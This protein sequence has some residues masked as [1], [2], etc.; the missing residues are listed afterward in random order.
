MQVP[1]NAP[2]PSPSPAGLVETIGGFIT[3]AG[4]YA[5]MAISLLGWLTGHWADLTSIGALL[6]ALYQAFRAAQ[7]RK[8]V[9]LAGELTYKAAELAE[10][11]ARGKREHVADRLYEMVGP[12]GRALFSRE[13]LGRAVEEGWKLIAKPRIAA[14]AS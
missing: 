11:T 4:P 10:L 14:E 13:E 1:L 5:A 6:L 3:V 9:G 2:T 7:W 8:V 12:V